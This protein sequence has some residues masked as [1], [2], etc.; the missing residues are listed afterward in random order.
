MP[1]HGPRRFHEDP[2]LLLIDVACVNL[3]HS[4]PPNHFPHVM[5]TDSTAGDYRNPF[6]RLFDQTRD[7]LDALE[8]GAR[9]AGS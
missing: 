4:S 9:T 6:P 1:L 8:S 5:R 3:P 7:S 2:H